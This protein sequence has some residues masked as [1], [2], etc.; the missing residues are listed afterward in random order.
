MGQRSRIQVL[1]VLEVLLAVL[2]LDYMRALLDR[3]IHRL[4]CRRIEHA[5]RELPL[6]E[7]VL[8]GIQPGP[9]D[10]AAAARN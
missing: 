10:H 1:R 2:R 7:H 6:T 4:L 8:D 5:V 9:G 3:L